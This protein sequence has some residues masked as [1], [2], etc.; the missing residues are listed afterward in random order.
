MQTILTITNNFS[1]ENKLGQGGFGPVY[2]VNF[3]M[4]YLLF[5][6][7]HPLS[8]SP[9]DYLQLWIQGNL[10]DGKEIAIKRLSSTSGQG[11]EEFMNEIILISKLQ[12]RN[13]VRLLGC[14]IEGEEKLLIYEFMANKSLNTFIFGQS[15]IVHIS[16]SFQLY[17]SCGTLVPLF[18]CEAD[19][20]V[21]NLARFDEKA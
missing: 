4:L 12:H 6:F 19:Q 16:A 17:S 8:C 11:L 9:Y 10:Q 3:I 21:F 20:S 14:C 18:M 15:L 1:M 7:C 13:L 2:K 5:F